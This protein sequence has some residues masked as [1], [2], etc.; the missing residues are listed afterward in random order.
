MDTILT[1]IIPVR[2]PDG[3]ADWQRNKRNLAAT[4]RSI[5]SQ[6]R[7]GWKAVIV[8]NRGTDLP[9]LPKGFA[10]EFVDLPPNVLLDRRFHH[11]EQYRDALRLD[12]GR[13][14]LAG[15]LHADDAGHV[16]RVDDDDFVH[17]GLTSFVAARPAAN[18]WYV[19]D[20]YIWT[21]GGKLLYR[22]NDFSGLCGTSHIVRRDLFRLPA[23]V[24]TADDAYIRRMLGSHIFIRDVL[25]KA[26]HPL[27]PLPFPG[28]VYRTGHAESWSGS[29]GILRQYFVNRHMAK[30]PAALLKS[31]RRLRVRSRRMDAMFFG[32]DGPFSYPSA[33]DTSAADCPP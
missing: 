32:R 31:A 14:L 33:G 22:H 5:A 26:G 27:D 18:G 16:M 1:F 17:R 7:N 4:V 19:K 20:G 21:D 15:L 9:D 23:S 10:V 24:D 30:H 2:H 13:R 12:L 11:L 25:A 6:D 29:Q 28:A 8:A 3:A